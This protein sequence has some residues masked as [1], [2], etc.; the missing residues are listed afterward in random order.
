MRNEWNAERAKNWHL[1]AP[2]ARP[3]GAEVARYAAALRDVP[4]PGVWGLLGST[5]ELR[6]LAAEAAQPLV[7][8]DRDPDVY[9]VLGGLVTTRAD[10]ERL[11]CSDWLAAQPE[12][13]FSV[14]MADGSL[15]MLSPDRHA[16]FF[17]AVRRML[18][19]GGVALI[20]VHLAQ[21]PMFRD[22]AAVFAW[23]R[24]R[25]N[26]ERV[27]TAT[28]THLDMLWLEPGS[29]RVD[30]PEYHARL[31]RLH[32]EGTITGEEFA[33]YHRL[34]R[35]NRISLWY[36]TRARF[37][38]LAAAGF[39]IEEI[40]FGCDYTASAQHPLYVLRRRSP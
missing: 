16:A 13:R 34:L 4:R 5:P 28:R 1:F 32:V 27:F 14:L 21:P 36:S 10:A 29:L 7:C 26:G 33:A 15:N 31:E 38:S 23:F 35:F 11:L 9:E 24:A 25:G 20:R 39:E 2:P 37:E 6:S 22:P 40:G 3:S 8:I 19:P 17:D 12:E 18:A 30:F